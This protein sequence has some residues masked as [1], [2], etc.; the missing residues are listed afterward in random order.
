LSY[1]DHGGAT[2]PAEAGGVV[3]STGFRLTVHRDTL[4]VTVDVRL[5]R[6]RS[7]DPAGTKY[8]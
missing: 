6:D 7:N 2:V 3:S 4:D 5:R 8:H 1:P